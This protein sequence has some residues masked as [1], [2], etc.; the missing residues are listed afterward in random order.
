M[1]LADGKTKQ[2]FW[3]GR[4]DREPFAFAGL[5]ERWEGGGQAVETFALL[6]T[7][8]NALM[9]PIHNR[10][11]VLVTEADFERWLEP[12]ELAASERQRL[13]GPSDMEGFEAFPVARLVSNPR[14]EGPDLMT[15]VPD[16]RE[17]GE[18]LF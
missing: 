12:T 5:W 4:L 10:M 1:T 16:P 6:T 13:I 14:L 9:A 8:P 7:T 3:I 15:R 11:P 17:S 2:P 18:F